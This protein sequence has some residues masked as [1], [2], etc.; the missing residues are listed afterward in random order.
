M[1]GTADG[2]YDTVRGI[3]IDGVFL[4]SHSCTIELQAV[5]IN[6]PVARGL[7]VCAPV[8]CAH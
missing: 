8:S 6:M 3:A 1:D 4:A 5:Q 2:V 7:Q